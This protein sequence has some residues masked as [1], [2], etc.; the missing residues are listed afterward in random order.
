MA[1]RKQKK[2]IREKIAELEKLD[3]DS[4]E[5]KQKISQIQE[6]FELYN[7]SDTSS[8]RKM[9]PGYSGVNADIKPNF[10]QGRR[11]YCG[12][13]KR[14]KVIVSPVYDHFFLQRKYQKGS[15]RVK[16]SWRFN[17]EGRLE[18]IDATTFPKR[19]VTHVINSDKMGKD[20]EWYSSGARYVMIGELDILNP[21]F[22]T[23]GL[24]SKLESLARFGHC[25]VRDIVEDFD[26]IIDPYK[27]H[28]DQ[29]SLTKILDDKDA[30]TMLD[31]ASVLMP[32]IELASDKRLDIFY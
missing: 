18:L 14:S 3:P 20:P 11:N 29:I 4:P 19:K 21:G 27:L 13:V 26:N 17:R 22:A 25:T 7:V 28:P 24:K 8:Y 16:V 1:T 23:L 10:D 6:M 2:D 15:N 5:A 9:L 12:M 32:F 31:R 30:P